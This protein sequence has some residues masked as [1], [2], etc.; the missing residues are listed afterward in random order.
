MA[1]SKDSNSTEPLQ[2]SAILLLQVM[3]CSW[4]YAKLTENVLVSR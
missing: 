2:Q 4:S 3:Y 1:Y